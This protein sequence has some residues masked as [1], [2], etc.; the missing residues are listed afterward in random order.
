DWNRAIELRHRAIGLCK[1]RA[2]I[3]E[4]LLEVGGIEE[5]Q[6]RDD[7]AALEA[8]QRVLEIEPSAPAALESCARLHRKAGRSQELLD[9]LRQQAQYV[10][11]PERLLAI[12]LEIAELAAAAGEGPEPVLA[13]Y[14]AAPAIDPA[15]DPALRGIERVAGPAGRRDVTAAAVSG[16]PEAPANLR[17]LAR[18]HRETE[19]WAPLAA[20]LERQIAAVPSKLEKAQLSRELAALYRDRLNSPDDAIRTYSRALQLDPHDIE[21]QRELVRLLEAGGRWRDLTQA[22]ERELG[23]VP[24]ADID[25][26][27]A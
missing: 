19:G 26:Q 10:T 7:A 13:A 17:A 23:T 9:T 14:Q 21:S 1:D 5:S 12:Q 22:L 25:R 15:S 20:V 4:L 11:Q 2:R 6:R 27:V 16:A 18:A 3:A 24:A 8:F